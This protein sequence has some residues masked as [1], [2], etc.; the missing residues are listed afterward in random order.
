MRSG[1]CTSA[2]FEP[3]KTSIGFD[4]G[5]F[6]HAYDLIFEHAINSK[7]NNLTMTHG[8]EQA[9]QLTKQTSG[10]TRSFPKSAEVSDN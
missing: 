1:C 7:Y 10:K 4:I 3:L 9:N 2:E 5:N 8:Y 6:C